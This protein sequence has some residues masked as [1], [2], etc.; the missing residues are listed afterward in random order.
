MCDYR[1]REVYD[2]I[3]FFCSVRFPCISIPCIR[4]IKSGL[5]PPPFLSN[6]GG[7][8]VGS[9]EAPRKYLNETYVFFVVVPLHLLFPFFPPLLLET[10]LPSSPHCSAWGLVA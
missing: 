8:M 7:G 10:P 9:G 4:D 1:K 6:E 3:H 5:H 2:S